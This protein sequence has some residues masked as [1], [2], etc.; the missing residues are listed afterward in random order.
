MF[1]ISKFLLHSF[2]I[3]YYFFIIFFLISGI[4]I[5]KVYVHAD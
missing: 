2:A 5:W 3:L 4:C 1:F